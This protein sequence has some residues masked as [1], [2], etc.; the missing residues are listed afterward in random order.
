MQSIWLSLFWKEWCE[1]RWKLAALTVSLLGGAAFLLSLVIA[2]NVIRDVYLGSATVV[3]FVYIFLAGI[4][5][6][7]GV[8]AG[9]QSRRTMRL[10]QAL[11][12]P[13]WQSA[14]AK[15]LV[16]MITV[17]VPVAL[18]TGLT[19][20]FVLWNGADVTHAIQFHFQGFGKPWGFDNWF[21]ARTVSGVLG[22]C[23]LLL[24]MTL[25]GVNRSDEI[26]AAAVGFLVIALVWGGFA[27]G[28]D[29]VNLAVEVAAE[30]LVVGL[31]GGPA[32]VGMGP[33]RGIGSGNPWLIGWGIF[34]HALL[35]ANYLYRFGRV[36]PQPKGRLESPDK[37]SNLSP[38]NL[39]PFRSPIGAIAWKQV[40]ETGPLALIA[41]AGILV[42]VPLLHK[43]QVQDGIHSTLSMML[44][45]VS[46]SVGIL[47]ALVSGIGV[48]LEDYSP[49]V[50]TFWRSRPVDL[51][52]W[53][54]VKYVTGFLVL[55]LTFGT[56]LLVANGLEGWQLGGP[57][58]GFFIGLAFA[59]FYTM[60]LTAFVLVR[61]PIYAAVLALA[62]VFP[63]IIIDSW[64]SRG[65][66]WSIGWSLI[67]LLFATAISL[68]WLAVKHDWGWKQSR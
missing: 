12:A 39:I 61:Q 23:S 22:T 57:K 13:T 25:G 46:I 3:L 37:V 29:R 48:L 68:A 2:D 51:C 67:F 56:V 11:P 52:L 54:G 28:V 65:L 17:S 32:M 14:L 34:C 41:I 5:M 43:I 33:S 35:L 45:S 58:D 49:G 50:N 8:S 60:A 10:L 27:Y 36:V 26:R 1:Q 31:P 7:V 42:L 19:W 40:R 24:W 66:H 15:L 6:G 55:A 63:A 38:S 47:V 16:A 30:H 4:F 64:F 44:A 62:S 21:L 53:F 59:W 18:L 9:E 20:A